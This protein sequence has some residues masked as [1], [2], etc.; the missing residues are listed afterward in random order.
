VEFR[1]CIDLYPVDREQDEVETCKVI[2]QLVLGLGI[3]AVD[4]ATTEPR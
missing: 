2:P 3:D 1:S 4:K